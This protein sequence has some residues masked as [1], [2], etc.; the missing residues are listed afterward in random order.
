M[1][2]ANL[3]DTQIIKARVSRVEVHPN[4]NHSGLES[5]YDIALLK[6]ENPVYYRRNI[7]PLC[8]PNEGWDKVQIIKFKIVF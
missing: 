5:G 4:Y 1:G 7:A 2:G 3:L 8:L 6:T